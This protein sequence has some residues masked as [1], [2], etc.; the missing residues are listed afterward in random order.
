MARNVEE[1]HRQLAAV[2]RDDAEARERCR[3]FVHSF[4]RPRG[5]EYP[6]SPF[7]VEEIERLARR[8]KPVAR[9]PLW[10]YPLRWTLLA[11][12]R[13]LFAAR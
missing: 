4:V 7:M 10:H 3:R 5:V 9:T 8:P 6:A 1:H 12:A 11:T 2:L 13:S